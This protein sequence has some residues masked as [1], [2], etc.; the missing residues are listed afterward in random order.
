MKCYNCGHDLP[1]PKEGITIK[2]CPH[3]GAKAID[4]AAEAAAA[5]KAAEE[6]VEAAPEAV[7][8][9]AEEAAETVAE[10]AEEA[11]AAVEE[12]AAPVVE[13]A[14]EA[15]AAVEEAAEAVPEAAAEAIEEAAAP[16]VE[17]A[18]EAAET[19][20]EAAE[21]VTEVVEE[22]PAA[23]AAAAA[24]IPPEAQAPAKKKS[25]APLIVII[26]V[27]ILAAAGYFVYQNLPSTKVSKFKKQAAELHEAGSY[28]QEIEVLK[29]AEAL[30]ADDMSLVKSEATA[31]AAKAQ[32]LLKDNKQEDAFSW[33]KDIVA[34]VE[35]LPEA[36]RAEYYNQ[37][38]ASMKQL[39]DDALNS[40]LYEDAE[41]YLKKRADIIPAVSGIGAQTE[42]DLLAVYTKWTEDV[43]ASGTKDDFVAQEG[44]IDRILGE[45]VLKSKTAELKEL[46]NKLFQGEMEADLKEAGARMLA[47]I[48][49]EMFG[50]AS[51]EVS[52][53]FGLASGSCHYIPIW[54]KEDPDKRV[55]VIADIDGTNKIGV[56]YDKEI[57][58]V[59]IYIGEYDG[60]KRSGKGTWLLFQG[61]TLSDYRC[62]AATG[63]W[64]NDKPNGEFSIYDATTYASDTSKS[65][66]ER[67]TVNVKDGVY[68]GEAVNDF[69]RDSKTVTYRP[70]YKDGHP[71]V[72]EDREQGG[73]VYHLI[74]FSE[75][76]TTFLHNVNGADAIVGI[77]GFY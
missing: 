60:T 22:A 11:T 28:E 48:K 52:S 56:Y 10:V 66:I 47:E 45:N 27:L 31:M 23:A 68:D 36:D 7:A 35:A 29:Q 67:I 74:A 37:I 14:E 59:R 41:N 39:S 42:N 50:V 61:T 15:V 64:A 49:S 19:V 73:T 72:L 25:K 34:R 63:T 13:A 38:S 71:V 75:D 44:V 69:T 26:I 76:K 62:Y 77:P 4:F 53:T 65:K 2:F 43:L 57:N 24:A 1:E 20:A 18:E 33:F 8:E 16:V 3:C 6:A 70:S 58:A 30:A 55:P 51:L 32:A 46:K 9:V 21:T 12:A 17:A 40:K 5:A 54:E